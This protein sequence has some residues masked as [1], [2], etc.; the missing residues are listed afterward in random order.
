MLTD[1]QMTIIT[2]FIFL[3][4]ILAWQLASTSASVD[5]GVAVDCDASTAG[6]QSSCSY[7]SGTAFSV[8]VHVTSAPG[9]GYFAHQ[10]K[11]RWDDARVHYLPAK[12]SAE[13]NL[14]PLCAWSG[15]VDNR[16]AV[17]PD[18]SLLFGCVPLPLPT[19]G[20][21]MTG[22]ILQ[23]RFQCAQDG[24]SVLAF[25]PREGDAQLGTHFLDAGLRPI[26][27]ARANATVVCGQ[28]AT[29][30]P[31]AAPKATSTPKPTATAVSPGPFEVTP[32]PT[33]KAT[34]TSP[35]KATPTPA[36]E[37][38]HDVAIVDQNRRQA[39]IQIGGWT[40]ALRA[41]LGDA[42]G[43][44]RRVGVVVQNRSDHRDTVRV[45]LSASGLPEGCWIDNNRD[46]LP[47]DTAGEREVSVA[48]GNKAS[49]AFSVTIECHT[50]RL[51]GDRFWVDLV[52]SI[53]HAGGGEPPS[54]LANNQGTAQGEVRVVSP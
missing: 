38:G 5:G 35:P 49:I 50:P 46:G 27:P 10:M 24:A 20:E 40:R 12:T 37:T 22:A 36:P 26:D 4:V 48:S 17:P 1:R 14:W 15:H 44:T 28:T 2:G 11:V 42:D 52:A 23:F 45:R 9:G 43:G 8:Q 30:P 51:V 53:E 41:P 16:T 21:T 29:P 7:P 54:A 32:P 18:A 19:Q 31:T 3:L 34:P 6:A 33:A 39:G 25:V 47:D 13:E